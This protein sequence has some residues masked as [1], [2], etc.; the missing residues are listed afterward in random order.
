MWA[1]S[2]PVEKQYWRGNGLSLLAQ[3]SWEANYD[4][5][6][7]ERDFSFLR[8]KYDSKSSSDHI[9][10]DI[11]HDLNSFFKSQLLRFYHSVNKL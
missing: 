5:L 3:T 1:L 11:H 10:K 2:L 6:V 8:I 4:A 9:I 7:M